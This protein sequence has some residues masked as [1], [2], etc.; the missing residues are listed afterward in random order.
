MLGKERPFKVAGSLDR[1]A[2]GGVIQIMNEREAGGNGE[3]K[4]GVGGGI[5]DNGETWES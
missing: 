5:I 1:V 3:G 2:G 4:G